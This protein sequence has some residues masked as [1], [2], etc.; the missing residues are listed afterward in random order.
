M[1]LLIDIIGTVF[2]TIGL[3]IRWA[4]I[5]FGTSFGVVSGYVAA[6]NII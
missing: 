5:G 3:V 4:I 6:I 1:K 2:F